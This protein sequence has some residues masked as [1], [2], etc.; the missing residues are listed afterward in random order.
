VKCVRDDP[1]EQ[2]RLHEHEQCGR[3]PERHVDAEQHP[4]R[5][6]PADEPRVERA[7]R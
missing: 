1:R 3:D 6:G 4:D 5:S 2:R 7:H